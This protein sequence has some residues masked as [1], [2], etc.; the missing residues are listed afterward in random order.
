MKTLVIIDDEFF[1][2]KSLCSYIEKQTEYEIIGEA[3][4]GSVGMEKIMNLKPAIAL[5]DISMPVMDGLEMITKLHGHTN[6]RFILLTGYAEFEYAK[7][8]ISLGVHDYLLKPVKHQELNKSLEKLSKEIDLE[9]HQQEIKSNYFQYRDKY[10]QQMDLNT[11]HKIISLQLT[12]NQFEN[13]LCKSTLNNCTEFIAMIVKINTDNTAVWNHASD[14][15]LCHSIL[16]NITLELFMRENISPLYIDDTAELQYVILGFPNTT[17][18]SFAAIQKICLNLMKTF[19]DTIHIPSSFFL[20]SVHFGQSGIKASYEEALSLLHNHNYKNLTI[21]SHFDSLHRQNNINTFDLNLYRELLS[22]LRQQ[23]IKEVE[24]QIKNYFDKM[25]T[26][27][28]HIKRIQLSGALFITVLD[29]FISEC[30]YSDQKFPALQETL[31]TYEHCNSTEELK[32]LFLSAYHQTLCQIKETRSSSQSKLITDAQKYI[33]SHYIDPDM[34]LSTI[35]SALYVSPQYLSA[36]FS[37][38][39]HITLSNYIN[40]YRMKK[41]KEILLAD[42]PSIQNTALLCGFTD[43]GYFSKCFKKYYG[44]SPKNFLMLRQENG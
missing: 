34:Q 7:K 38:E 39:I 21:L 20:G 33:E 2:R 43:A 12:D 3:N 15:E 14:R 35:A 37:R 26:E 16:K 23:K 4:N 11:F 10:Q 28:W 25:Q 5:V 40:T 6:T 29:E 18:I 24:I 27:N 9:K 42:S 36:T 8:A 30:G 32:S 31:D 1:F 22:L 19:K 41:A 44:I 13:Y 17:N